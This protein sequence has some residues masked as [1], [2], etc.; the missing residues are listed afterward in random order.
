MVVLQTLS[1]AWGAAGIR[2]GMAFASPEIVSI[3]N[4]IKYPYNINQLTQ[5][6]AIKILNRQEDV[7]TELSEIVNERTLMES[8]LHELSFV[9]QI[10]PSDANFILVR[11]D[12]ANATYNYLVEKGIIVR[13]RHTVTLCEGCLRIT[14][15]TPAQNNELL[16]ALQTRTL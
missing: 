10:Y 8:A 7:N 12:Y 6:Y 13:N 14:I 15:G 2:L 11:V 5:E 4:K 9:K 1:K 3:L 16:K